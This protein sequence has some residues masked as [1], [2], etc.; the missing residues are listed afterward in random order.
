MKD[1]HG[2]CLVEPL[3][4]LEFLGLMRVAATVVTDSGGVQEETSILG[5][6][7]VTVRT[8]TERPVTCRLGTN[9]LVHPGDHDGII[10]A[11]RSG[12]RQSMAATEIPLWDG[13]AAER[14]VEEL[15]MWGRERLS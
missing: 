9:H 6:P 1:S 13:H 8:S 2:I 11:V 5:V 14:V 15:A 7:C 4:Y 12:C 3:G 10:A